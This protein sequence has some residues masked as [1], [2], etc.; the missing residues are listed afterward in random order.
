MYVPTI[1][2]IGWQVA[3]VF[4]CSYSTLAITRSFDKL[5]LMGVMNWKDFRAG[6]KGFRD[7]FWK[8]Q[9]DE[10]FVCF[11]QWTLRSWFPSASTWMAFGLRQIQP[12]SITRTWFFSSFGT[13]AILMSPTG[14]VQPNRPNPSAICFGVAL[15]ISRNKWLQE[16]LRIQL[17]QVKDSSWISIDLLNLLPSKAHWQVKPGL[18]K[19]GGLLQHP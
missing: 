11:L 10:A 8:N 15:R 9:I 2:R 16:L 17:A 6:L 13:V 7:F 5:R 12:Q 3:V 1:P 18:H 14:N 19:L 4:P